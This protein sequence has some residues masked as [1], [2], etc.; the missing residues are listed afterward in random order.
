VAQASSG[1]PPGTRRGGTD[2]GEDGRRTVGLETDDGRGV[3]AEDGAGLLRDGSEHLGRRQPAGDQRGDP[4]QRG[5]LFGEPAQIVAALLEM[6]AALGV[7]GRQGFGL[8]GAARGQADNP[9]DRA[10]DEDERDQGHYVVEVGDG[11]VV[12]RG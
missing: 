10:S 2:A 9:A 5:L 11:E 3:G 4:P 7:R 12:R 1:C 8:P 6:G